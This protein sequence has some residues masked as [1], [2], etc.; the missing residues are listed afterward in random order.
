MSSIEYGAPFTPRPKKRRANSVLYFA[1]TAVILLFVVVFVGPFLF[2]LDPT[3]VNLGQT[4]QGPSLAHPLG[5][6]SAGRDLLAR[7]LVGGRA[8][9]LAPLISTVLATLLGTVVGVLAA[10]RGGWMR[11]VIQRLVETIF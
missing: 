5:T 7:I 8:S 11:A 10:W 9:L 2:R 3:T 1:S 4:F 6:D